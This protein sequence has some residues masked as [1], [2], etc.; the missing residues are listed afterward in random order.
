MRTRAEL[1]V[2]D[3]DG[4]I[5]NSEPLM[6]TAFAAACRACGVAEPPAVEMFL[7]CMGMPL[8]AIAQKLG[9]PVRFVSTYQGICRERMEMVTLYEGATEFL[10]TARARFRHLALM[11]GKDR[12]RTTLLLERVRILG[13]FDAMVCGDDPYP[14]KPDPAGLQALMRRFL[15]GPAD[16]TMIGDSAIDIRCGIG[17]GARTLGAGWGFAQ[18]SELSGAG[19]ALVFDRPEQFGRWL[20]E[21]RTLSQSSVQLITEREVGRTGTNG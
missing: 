17:A 6:R 19:A 14:G 8:P 12:S 5:V 2:F 7:A 18:A 20:K 10:T 9:L 21:E 16:T 15:V 3:L 13:R 11:T 4:V 1:F